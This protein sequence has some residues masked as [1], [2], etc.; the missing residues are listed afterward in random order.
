[1]L[2]GQGIHLKFEFKVKYRITINDKF[3]IHFKYWWIT[4]KTIL[5]NSQN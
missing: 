2:S 5:N 4:N 1:M 3:T